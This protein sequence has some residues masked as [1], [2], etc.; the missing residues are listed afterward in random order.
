MNPDDLLIVLAE[1]SIAFVGFASIVAALQANRARPWSRLDRFMFR[2][3]VEAGILSFF[4]CVFPHAIGSFDV[5]E[6]TIW[7]GASAI[8]LVLGTASTIRRIFQSRQSL[9][10][11]PKFGRR[12]L[13]PVVAAMLI[14]HISNALYLQA[15]GPYVVS[16]LLSILIVAGMFL[17]LVIRLFP[18]TDDMES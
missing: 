15:A 7:S 10:E 13:L 4:T 18:L 17:F 1:V 16:V 11:L 8:S 12:F 5:Q 14:L 3:M 9:D 6:A 2:A